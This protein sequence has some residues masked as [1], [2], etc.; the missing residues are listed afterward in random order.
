MYKTL[1]ETYR[2]I[3]INKDFSFIALSFCLL[4]LPFSINLSSYALVISLTLKLVQALFFKDRLFYNNLLRQSFYIGLSFFS[5]VLLSSIIQIG[6]QTTFKQFESEY[7]KLA[8]FFLIPLILKDKATNKL[9]IH[10]FFIGVA[11]TVIYVI[12]SCLLNQLYFDRTA[13]QNIVDIHHTYLAMYL[14][15]IIN[16]LFIRT[17]VSKQ[18]KQ[19][20]VKPLYIVAILACFFVIYYLNSKISIIIFSILV[21]IHLLPQL[22]KNKAPKLFF[23]FIT[24][25][26]LV[27]S[28][29]K[30]LSVSYKSALDFRLEIWNTS[31]KIIEKSPLFGNLTNTEKNLLNYE[32]YI[33]GDYFFLDSDLNSHN[34]YLS[35]LLKY[36]IFGAIL[37]LL[38]VVVIF[39]TI[40]KRTGAIPIREFIG[41]AVIISL[42]FYI[43]NIF[44]RHHGIVFLSMFYNYYLIAIQNAEN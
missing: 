10:T 13:F 32:H 25:S 5:F 30:R 2:K 34:Q 17:V 43:E 41:F 15:F 8:L 7:S 29:N 42:V 14:L 19:L 31:A 18:P 36:G 37:L 16:Y 27:F 26:V 11:A 28:F 3:I 4:L 33:E 22:S 20:W 38:H 12:I 40:N 6:L 21:L 1:S 35:I 44:D 23:I 9:L 39:K 24:L